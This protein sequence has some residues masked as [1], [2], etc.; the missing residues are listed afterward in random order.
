MGKTKQEGEM[1]L[2]LDKNFL[3]KKKGSGGREGTILVVQA[4]RC[5]NDG[6]G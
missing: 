2:A 6:L 3:V 1:Y 4:L 5:D